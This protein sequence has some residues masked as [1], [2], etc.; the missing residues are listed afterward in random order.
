MNSSHFM[1]ALL[2]FRSKK[3]AKVEDIEREIMNNNIEMSLKKGINC[4]EYLMAA[5]H[6]S[7]RNKSMK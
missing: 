6:A 7:N 2:F 4:D 1:K 5:I 3:F